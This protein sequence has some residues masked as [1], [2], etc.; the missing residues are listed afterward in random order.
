MKRYVIT[1][2]VDGEQQ[3]QKFFSKAEAFRWF[4]RQCP[5][6]EATLQDE[7]ERGVRGPAK[8]LRRRN[9]AGAV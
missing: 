9:P 1:Y 2:T 7:D 3:E 8:L 5:V 6:D 4:N